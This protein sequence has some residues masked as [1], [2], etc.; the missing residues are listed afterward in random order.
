MKRGYKLDVNG[1]IAA[2]GGARAIVFDNLESTGR[3]GIG[4]G[5][6]NGLAVTTMFANVGYGSAAVGL[7]FDN[8]GTITPSLIVRNNGRVGIGTDSPGAALDVRGSMNLRLDNGLLFFT[9]NNTAGATNVNGGFIGMAHN[10]GYHVTADDGGFGSNANSL[11]IGNYHTGGGDIILA[12]TNAGPYAS[13]RVIIKENGNVGIGTD[14][15]DAPLYIDGSSY[16]SPYG[17]LRVVGA[18]SGGGTSNVDLIADFGIGTSGSV[19]GIW[20]GGRSDQTTGVIG[21]K[22]ASGNLAFEVYSGGWKERLRISNNGNVG[23]G[24]TDPK[25]KLHVVG[26][27]GQSTVDSAH[28]SAVR[29]LYEGTFVNSG[30]VD[31]FTLSGSELPFAGTVYI[32]AYKSSEGVS[33]VWTA[34][35]IYPSVTPVVNQQ[36]YVTR[37]DEYI[38]LAWSLNGYTPTLR[39]TMGNFSG[40]T[41]YTILVDGIVQQN[42]ST[43]EGA[44]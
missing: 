37:S 21:A 15:P 7:G 35:C 27:I 43:P 34:A 6:Y 16:S 19:S 29:K 2:R 40:T 33:G 39:V 42:Y 38:T 31:L 25:S 11:L 10:A 5:A 9:D 17:G 4:F 18:G 23:V 12:T 1:P 24:S 44:L 26:T 28:P 8:N 22:T 3:Y 36:S 20:L 14:S 30:T 41:Y 32:S 13:G